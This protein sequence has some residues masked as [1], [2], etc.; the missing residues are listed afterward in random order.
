MIRNMASAVTVANAP[1]RTLRRLTSP[2]AGAFTSVLERRHSSSF[3]CAS[4][5]AFSASA[6]F[7]PSRAAI[8]TASAVLAA[9]SRWSKMLSERWP[10][11]RSC[12]A[13]SS[14]FCA[15][16]NEAS[17]CAIVLRAW[18]IAASAFARSAVFWASWAS[19]VACTR[20]AST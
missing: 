5:L 16:F 14:A 19:S 9:A 15:S 1:T 2:S 4:R 18:A 8:S 10:D 17:A 11:L 13:R 20:V 6:T 7:N 12:L 3:L